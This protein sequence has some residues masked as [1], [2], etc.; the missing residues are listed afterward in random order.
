MKYGEIMQYYTKELLTLL[1]SFYL[2]SCAAPSLSPENKIISFTKSMDNCDIE[3]DTCT[4]VKISYPEIIFPSNSASEKTLNEYIQKQLVLPLFGEHDYANT[5]EMISQFFE[6][7]SQM[8]TE[9]GAFN[10]PWTLEKN[11]EVQYSTA[12]II[13]IV[14]R[15]YSFA[16]GAHP[17]T[18][19]AFNSIKTIDGSLIRISDLIENSKMDKFKSMMNLEFKLQN[20][21]DP[22][23]SLESAGFW[24]ND[25]FFLPE[26]F[27]ITE[28]GISFFYNAYEIAAYAVGTSGIEVS[29]DKLKSY[30]K[31]DIN[32]WNK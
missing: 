24:F 26:N 22:D 30:L 5:D 27:I 8:K 9:Y 20:D 28:N 19:Y 18:V 15:T 10:I 4:F 2:F 3:S 12:D 6:E 7:Y 1:I 16:G 17:N 23:S 11:I 13:S 21:V 31:N 14:S 29:V 25:G 32:Y